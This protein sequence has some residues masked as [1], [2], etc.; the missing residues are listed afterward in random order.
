[1]SHTTG[2]EGISFAIPSNVARR[3]YEDIIRHGRVIYPWF[4]VIMRPLTPSLAQQLRLP[5]TRGALVDATLANS[6]AERS[7][8][9]TGDV[10]LSFNDRPI[11]D[12]KDLKNRV[13]EAQVGTPANFSILRNGKPLALKVVM[14]EAPTN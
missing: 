5:G 8:L 12:W 6:P 9:Q 7:G 3:V 13:A 2:S 10:I 11:L 14:E 4:G 1:M